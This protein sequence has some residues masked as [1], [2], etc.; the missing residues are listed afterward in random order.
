MI[1]HAMHI[2][3]SIGARYLWVDSI[4]LISDDKE[5]LT[6][7]L[8]LMGSIYARAKLTIVATD[9]DA[10]DGL[11]GIQEA[12]GAPGKSRDL[13]NTFCYPNGVQ[14]TVRDQPSLS[15]ILG[16]ASEYFQRGWTYQEYYLS[17]RR[18]IFG[19]KQMHW[20]CSCATWHEDDPDSG[21]DSKEDSNQKI[22]DQH[23]QISNILSGKT[24]LGELAKLAFEYHPRDFTRPDDALPGLAGLLTLLTRTFEGGFL[25]GHPETWFDAALMWHCNF[26]GNVPG[27]YARKPTLE[28]RRM[29]THPSTL[30]GAVLPS[31]SWIGWKGNQLRFLDDEEDFELPQGLTEGKIYGRWRYI[32]TP[33]TE[34][35][36]HETTTSTKRRIQSFPQLPSGGGDMGDSYQG[37]RM[38]T[39]DPSRHPFVEDEKSKFIGKS[40]YQHPTIPHAYFWAPFPKFS[41][42]QGTS[43]CA[44][45]QYQYISC[46]TK[47]GWFG[48]KSTGSDRRPKS[49]LSFDAQASLT[50]DQG[51]GCGWLQ[52]APSDEIASRLRRSHH[53]SSTDEALAKSI[54][55]L[56]IEL[57]AVCQRRRSCPCWPWTGGGCNC[58]KDL[59]GVLWVEWVDGVAYRRGCGYV[60]KE[61]WDSHKLEDVDLVLG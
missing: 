48:V 21:E 44:P 33:V 20:S 39:Y 17:Q 47:R 52:L 43:I 51:R 32:T 29:S 36:S 57:V 5:H 30:P 11:D 58:N 50:D 4:C 37:W 10:W 60:M 35:Y 14:I 28:R 34:W 19:K 49:G 8:Q 13:P 3:R 61:M 1:H 53:G 23:F 55:E 16:S 7:Q 41:V 15:Q 46:R 54:A 59:C 45:K 25:C 38:E 18:L 12:P 40:V 26:H 31:W 42:G 6:E 27:G 22:D 24:D 56:K 9:G 2:V